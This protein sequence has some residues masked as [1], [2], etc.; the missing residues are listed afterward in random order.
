M[1]DFIKY[2]EPILYEKGK[3]AKDLFN[4]NVLSE[5]TY[6]KLR[7]RFPSLKSLIKIANYLEVNIDYIF[8]INV[9]NEFKPYKNS[10]ENFYQNLI[11]YLKLCDISQRKLLKDLGLARAN[12]T[13]WKNGINPRVENL[14]E[15][16]NYLQCSTNDLLERKI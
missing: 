6:Y 2:I 16:T 11:K 4:D 15:I 3:T 8:E 5:N 9:K 1:S 14:L 13:R 7:N 12:M 10:Q